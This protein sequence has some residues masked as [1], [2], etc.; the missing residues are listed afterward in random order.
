MGMSIRLPTE[1]LIKFID[2][3]LAD[4]DDIAKC[5]ALGVSYS[6]YRKYRERQYI[7][8]KL[9]DKLATNLGRH[10]IEIW[11]EWYKVCA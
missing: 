7:S 6:A 2:H 5:R 11:G 4:H 10:P 3:H 1:P 9:A 8:W